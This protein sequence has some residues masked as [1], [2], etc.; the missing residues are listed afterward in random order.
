MK[1]NMKK[2]TFEINAEDYGR[3]HALETLAITN[4][5]RMIDFVE[6]FLM[7]IDDPKRKLNTEEWIQRADWMGMKPEEVAR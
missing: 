6:A 5:G 4:D 1:K 3:F 2:V 7:R